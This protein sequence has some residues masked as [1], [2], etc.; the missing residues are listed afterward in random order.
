MDTE[1]VDRLKNG[2][3]EAKLDAL[4]LRL[5]ENIVMSFGV[6]PMNGFS[7][8]VFTSEAGPVALI[9]PSCEDEE[10]DGCWAKQVKYFTWPKLKMKDPLQAI[11]GEL[12]KIVKRHKLERARIGYEGSFE[13]VAPAHNAGEAMVPCESSIAWLKSL[14]PHAKWRDATDFL[15]GQRATKTPDEIE[16]LRLAHQV[17]DLGLYK[18]HSAAKVGMT[19]AE[20]AAMVYTECLTKG[21]KLPKVRHVNVYPQV[22]SGANSHRAWRP[23]V[24][25]GNLSLRSGRF[26]VLELA[27]CVNGFWADVTRVKAV[28]RASPLQREVFEAVKAAQ[29]AALESIRTGVEAHVPHEAATQ[30]FRDAGMQ[31]YMVHLTGHGLGFR[32]HE[33]EPF[34]MPGNTQKLRVGHVCSV[35]PGLYD[36]SF[37]G[38][39][40]EDNIAVTEDGAEV[41][42]KAP[43]VM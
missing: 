17:A 12:T 15:H 27:V 35:E 3:R 13:C 37:G 14:I 2:L 5:P 31:K 39:R 42:T 32:Y 7:Y 21:V 10:M 11:G 26:A 29:L 18:F 6:W 40:I 36:L 23:V 24:T 16:Q 30:V 33:P 41:L 1:R 9:A 34:L 8:A 25:T 19:E 38:V 4:I 20:A 22:S 28:G 43:R